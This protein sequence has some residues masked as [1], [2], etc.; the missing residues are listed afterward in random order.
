M[1]T[2]SRVSTL[3]NEVNIQLK[4]LEGCWWPEAGEKIIEG[5]IWSNKQ[6]Y[7]HLSPLIIVFKWFHFNVN[8]WFDFVLLNLISPNDKVLELKKKTFSFGM[9]KCHF[10]LLEASKDILILNLSHESIN[11]GLKVCVFCD[12]LHSLILKVWNGRFHACHQ[13][14]L[15]M[16]LF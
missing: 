2:I 4:W 5:Q 14:R 16:Q 1:K 3:I 7:P 10:P 13:W 15:C 9:K 8:V 11:L 6:S 12:H